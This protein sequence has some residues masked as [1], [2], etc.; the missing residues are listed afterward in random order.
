MQM[1]RTLEAVERE[2]ERGISNEIS[3]ICVASKYRKIGYKI[4]IF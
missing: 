2:R 3:F 4:G 1:A